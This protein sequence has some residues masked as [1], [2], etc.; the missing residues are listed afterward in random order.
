MTASASVGVA[1]WG[2]VSALGSDLPAV[3]EAVAAGQSGLRPD[4]QLAGMPGPSVSGRVQK[5]PLR[6]F[7]RRRKDKK[8]MARPS[9]LALV[10]F[11][12]ALG[13]GSVDPEACAVHVGVGREPPDD[14]QARA[15]LVASAREGQLDPHRLATVGRDLYPPLLPLQTLPNMAL[16]H[17]S[18]NL[19]LQGDNG[20][21]AGGRAAGLVAVQQALYAITEGRA[22]AALAGAADSQVDRGSQRDRLRL[23]LATPPGEAAG[24]LLLTPGPAPIR[25]RC[26]ADPAAPPASDEASMRAAAFGDCGAADG[27]LALLLAL[28]RVRR[29]GGAERICMADGRLAPVTLEIFAAT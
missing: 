20:A 23:G 24:A 15:S 5:L 13:S 25:L 9:Q 22:S 8:L 3:A 14:G 4:P 19:G 1:G 2:L 26:V 21:W 7:L 6:D 28:D 18:I 12:Q 17:V 16:A 29:T 10:A 27:V 11:G